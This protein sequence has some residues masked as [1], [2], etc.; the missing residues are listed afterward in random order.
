[1][2]SLISDD[3]LKN[4][5]EVLEKTENDLPKVLDENVTI[6]DLIKNQEKK[7]SQLIQSRKAIYLDT[8]YWLS[9][10]DIERRIKTDKVWIDLY[11]LIKQKIDEGKIFCPL[12]LPIFLELLRQ[13]DPVSKK[14]TAKIMQTLSLGVGLEFFEDRVYN[15]FIDFFS[16]DKSP[17]P[18]FGNASFIL[19]IPNVSD[20]NQK[21]LKSLYYLIS[22][23]DFQFFSSLVTNDSF[24]KNLEDKEFEDWAESLNKL[25]ESISTNE[26]KYWIEEV[27]KYIPQ[28]FN[29]LSLKAYNQ[30]LK[31]QGKQPLPNYEEIEQICA[32][33]ISYF[34]TNIKD[35]HDGKLDF[36]YIYCI[37][38]SFLL[39]QKERKIQPH[40]C[41]DVIHAAEAISSCDYYFTERFFTN[42]IS[43]N[44]VPKTNTTLIQEYSIN[45]C[46][47]PSDAINLLKTI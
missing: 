22:N 37:L 17:H 2:T 8:N 44:K 20:I 7:T 23:F 1:M 13:I 10:R 39:N 28:T 43:T 19:G 33:T 25:K 46:A 5:F 31:E 16:K 9:F 45:V 40:D 30:S 26:K 24:D 15:D 3:L 12:S 4:F 11:M 41:Y 47:T 18:L 6:D 21:S 32:G 35:F 27:L 29:E 38:L 34:L 36:L 14:K 42:L